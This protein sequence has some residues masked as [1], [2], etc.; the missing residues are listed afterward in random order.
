MEEGVVAGGADVSVVAF[1]NCTEAFEV[2]A[3]REREMAL[4]DW[5]VSIEMG[6]E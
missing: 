6:W 2:K 4:R 3:R 1:Y 5:N